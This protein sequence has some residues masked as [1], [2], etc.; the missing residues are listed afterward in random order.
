MFLRLAGETYDVMNEILF[1][2]N[3]S[4]LFIRINK[5][6]Y[7]IVLHQHLKELTIN[8]QSNVQLNENDILIRDPIRYFF[9][10]LDSYVF[11]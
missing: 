10:L 6:C 11:C 8:L 5:K 2:V 9:F 7:V 3:R 4:G 1:F